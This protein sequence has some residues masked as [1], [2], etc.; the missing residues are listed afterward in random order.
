MIHPSLSD[1]QLYFN[2]IFLLSVETRS[3]RKLHYSWLLRNHQHYHT[4]V[5]QWAMRTMTSGWASIHLILFQE[6]NDAFSITNL[7]KTNHSI[8]LFWHKKEKSDIQ[9][10]AMIKCSGVTW[11]SILVE[12]SLKLFLKKKESQSTRQWSSGSVN[13]V[14]K[15]LQVIN[16]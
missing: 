10:T 3:P 8:R 14:V 9:K 6:V 2:W 16:P 4:L 5:P 13:R 1:F 7:R 12:Q 15:S 11:E